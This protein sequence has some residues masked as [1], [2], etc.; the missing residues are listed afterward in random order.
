MAA[1]GL[2]WNVVNTCLDAV[3]YLINKVSEYVSFIPGSHFSGVYV[4]GTTVWLFY[5]MLACLVVW[6]VT[7]RGRWLLMALTMAL[8][9]T[10]QLC[11]VKLS[12]PQ[13]TVIILNDYRSTP[14]IW[15]E[16]GQSYAWIPD[17]RDTDHEL[18]ERN[19]RRLLA[20]LGSDSLC[21]VT[22][23]A[24][25]TLSVVKAPFAML[26]GQRIMLA[27]KGSSSELA[28]H[29]GD[30]DEVDVLIVTKRFHGSISDI[31]NQGKCQVVVLSGALP[32]EMSDALTHECQQ[33]GITCHD[34]HQHGA[35]QQ[36]PLN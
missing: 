13:A 22:D 26:Q 27:D 29:L 12:T 9:T 35:W 23:S 24:R 16:N 15:H 34:L 6:F 4:T 11:Y 8:A 18:F 20:H 14:I 19:H 5:G 36:L 32:K 25:S 2:E 17:A 28:S 1:L 10:V 21:W 7:R 31:L 33:R 30:K 3:Y